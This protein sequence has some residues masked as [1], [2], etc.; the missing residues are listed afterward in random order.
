LNVCDTAVKFFRTYLDKSKKGKEAMEYLLKRGVK[1]ETIADWRLGY[2]PESWS[3]LSDFLISRG[4]KREDIVKAGLAIKK[5]EYKF[6]DRFRSRI[7]FPICGFNG[8]VIGFTGRI[9][10]K[11]NENEAKYLNTP[12]TLL[13]DK[14]KALFG[15][16]KA[17]LDIRKNDACVLVEGN[18]DCIMSHQAGQVNCVAVSGTALTPLHLG[19]IKRYSPN[20]VLAFDT[21]AAG[22]KATQKGISLAQKMEFSVKVIPLSDEK[23]P[24]DIVLHEGEEKWKQAVT[25]AKP[26]NEFYFDLAFKG[27]NPNAIEDKKKIVAMLLPVYK[28]IANAIEQSHWLDKLAHSLK[29]KEAD[30]RQEMA[31]IKDDDNEEYRVA[32]TEPQLKCEKTRLEMIE[33][34]ALFFVLGNRAFADT[35]DLETVNLF[36]PPAKDIILKIKEEPGITNE[37]LLAYFSD[38]KEAADM[39]NYLLLKFEISGADVDNP[40][41][42]LEKCLTERDNLIKR[43]ARGEIILKIKEC[44]NR[45]D[46]EPLKEL[47]EEFNKLTKNENEKKAQSEEKQEAAE[48]EK[49]SS[50]ESETEEKSEAN[51]KE[52][53]A[54]KESAAESE[55]EKE[56]PAEEEKG[57]GEEESEG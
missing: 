25:G 54:E 41:V 42:E 30:L 4:F 56:D 26:V 9:F 51:E 33:E 19:I 17:K 37:A 21:D 43:Q 15:I 24:A 38:W 14:S 23:D 7:M 39:L 8:E 57:G 48:K 32:L 13:Y 20:L 3:Q 46:S 47:L 40:G 50:G 2:A 52:S 29:I 16:D 34:E 12:N 22:N 36:L 35:L 53:I 11:E 49:K 28:K 44:E 27:R 6:F 1:E 31:K 5:D 55:A 45:G 18:M 10:G